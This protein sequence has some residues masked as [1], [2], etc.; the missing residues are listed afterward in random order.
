MYDIKFTKVCVW[1]G[2]GEVRRGMC[3]CPGGSSMRSVCTPSDCNRAWYRAEVLGGT[4][5]SLSVCVCVCVCVRV[6]AC[7]CVCVW[8]IGMCVWVIGMCVCV[9]VGGGEELNGNWAHI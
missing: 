3:V 4:M 2:G 6:C 9:C 7:V 1:V 5:V 8:V